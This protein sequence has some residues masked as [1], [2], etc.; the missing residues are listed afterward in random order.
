[1]QIQGELL[2]TCMQGQLHR[3]PQSLYFPYRLLD[4]LY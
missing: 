4:N 1:M 2:Q 3:D